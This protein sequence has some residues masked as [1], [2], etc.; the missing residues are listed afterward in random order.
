MTRLVASVFLVATLAAVPT[1]ALAVPLPMWWNTLDDDATAT[2]GGGV[3]QNGPLA[4]TPGADGNALAGNQPPTPGNTNNGRWISWGNAAVAAIFESP[5]NAWNNALGSTVDLYFSG[6]H[7]STH[8]GDSGLW[9]L[10]ARGG[11]NESHMVIE[12]QNGKLRM[13]YRKDGSTVTVHLLTNVTLAD[14]TTYRLTVRQLDTAFEAYL[15]GTLVYTGTQ[16]GGTVPLPSGGTTGRAMVVGSKTS[17]STGALQA[18]E[19]VDNVRVYN[20]FFTPATIDSGGSPVASFTATP[21]SGFVPLTVSLNGSGSYDTDATNIITQY[22]W[23]FDNNG[24][25]DATGATTSHVY[26]TAGD[27]VCKL[28]VTD[29]ENETASSTVPVHVDAPPPA[30]LLTVT[31]MLPTGGPL[32]GSQVLTS[33]TAGGYTLTSLVGPT[34]AELDG[35]LGDFTNTGL[36]DLGTET[37]RGLQGL[38]LGRGL[39]SPSGAN[40]IRGYFPANVTINGDG[41]GKPEIFV[42]EYAGSTD[43]FQVQLLT[44]AP[45]QPRVVAAI[46]QVRSIDYIETSTQM[47]ATGQGVGGVGIDLDALSVS[48]ITGV[49]I[50]GDDGLGGQT[51]LDLCVIAA[52]VDPALTFPPVAVIRAAPTSGGAP[53]P[54]SFDASCGSY[55][56]DGELTYE[57]DYT[58]N[59]STDDTGTTANHLYTTAGA[60]MATLTAR[61]ADNLTAT[62]AVQINVSGANPKRQITAMLPSGGLPA[63][64]HA[65]TSISTEM[66]GGAQTF[67]ATN[68]VGPPDTAHVEVIGSMDGGGA[69]ATTPA[70]AMVG[71]ELGSKVSGL[72]S[73]GEFLTGFFADD[74]VVN[75]DGT[76]APEIFVIEGSASTDNFQIDLLTSGSGETVA[77]AATLQVFDADYASTATVIGGDPR[78]GLGIDLDALGVSSIRGVRIPGADGLGG[79]SGVDPVL[80]VGIPTRCNTP[81]ADADGDGDVDQADFT[82]FQ[83]CFTAGT[84]LPGAF[85]AAHCFCFDRDQDSDVDELDYSDFEDCATGPGVLWSPESSPG[86]RP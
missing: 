10:W 64:S 30:G 86:C 39:T 59:G 53:L 25:V 66:P 80:I 20:G 17:W 50:A 82:Q 45:G 83:L 36:C 71:L 65:L 28:T 35:T 48:G 1:A 70:E 61:D 12:V 63:G 49:Q 7:W 51:G 19:W 55:D 85:D 42:L 21:A 72:G 8:T 79:G 41:T 60:F 14:N 37:F 40:A 44:N 18:G 6:N 76:D 26:A 15:N 16:T 22:Q 24:S 78:G 84:P 68:L 62:D 54:V 56:P 23:D 74:V 67:T 38:Q 27:Y 4:F 34:T 81:F 32:S 29:D 46:I 3:V 31:D 43:N 13:P 69:G 2:A 9:A 33:V 47:S 75:A 73:P 57:W 77:V 58:T 52:A 11:T 5:G